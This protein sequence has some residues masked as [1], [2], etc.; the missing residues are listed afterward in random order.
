M[1]RF[2]RLAGLALVL[3]LAPVVAIASDPGPYLYEQLRK[4]EYK[5]TFTALFK[6]QPH[7]APWLKRYLHNRD[8]V[9]APMETRTVEGE[10]YELY[11]VCQPHNCG[12]N[13]IY[14]LFTPGGAHAWVMF[15]KDGENERFFGD[16]GDA[17][18]SALRAAARL[19]Q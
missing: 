11:A 4:P 16:P 12:G 14:V 9:D 10:T 7:V 13:F 17:M 3:V 18:Q 5:A 1:S 8:G 19:P 2:F 15:T 6:G